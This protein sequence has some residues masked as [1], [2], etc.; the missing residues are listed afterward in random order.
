M[1]CGKVGLIHEHAS[2]EVEGRLGAKL[3]RPL[4]LVG[5]LL[6]VANLVLWRM[7]PSFL[8][9]AIHYSVEITVGKVKEVVD[10]FKN[11]DISVKVD[12][13]AVLHKLQFPYQRIPI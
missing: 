8:T 1:V 5:A 2:I 13:L 6:A 12:H 3:S 4:D 10:V 7:A 9:E 11:L